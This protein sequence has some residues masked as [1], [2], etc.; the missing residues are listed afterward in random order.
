MM[1]V[2]PPPLPLL[3]RDSAESLWVKHPLSSRPYAFNSLDPGIRYGRRCRL[4]QVGVDQSFIA[5]DRDSLH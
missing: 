3:L 2:L 5:L 1:P 4:D